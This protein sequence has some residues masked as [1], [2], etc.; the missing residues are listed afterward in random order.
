VVHDATHELYEMWRANI[1]STGFNGGCAAVWDLTRA[2]GP[3]LRGDGCTSADAGGFPI[4]AMLATADEAFAGEIKHALR[5][6]LPNARIRHAVF[7][8]PGTH[9]T[10]P[11]A[12]GADAPPYGVRFRLRASYP[13]ASLASAG[14]RTLA[15]AL[16]R[17]GMFLAD[18]GNVPLTVQGDRFTTH[19][20][21]EVAMNEQSLGALAP[22]DFEVVDMGA[23]ITNNPDCARN[24]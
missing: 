16:Q 14:A 4:T 13:V 11:T 20:W 15:T 24:P 5:F 21:S 12:G 7:V 2:Y 6:I 17:Y 10:N 8:H 19:K 18:G 1:D 22:G 23:P 3:S 9:T